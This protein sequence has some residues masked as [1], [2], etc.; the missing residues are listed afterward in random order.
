LRKAFSILIIVGILWI[1]GCS[2]EEV[3]KDGNTSDIKEMVEEYSMGDFP[4]V[5]ATITNSELIVVNEKEEEK[6]YHLPEE[7][8]FLSIA[9]YEE[10]THPCV[11]H[12]LTGCQGEMVNE[13]VQMEI[14]NRDGE[15][16]LNEEMQTMDNGFIDLW[17]PRNDVYQVKIMHEGKQAEAILSTSDDGQ[18]CITTM[19]LKSV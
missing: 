8:F 16:I 2:G 10:V 15:L 1:A 4:D 9:P 18:T 13:T 11:D 7:E 17:L 12:S 6:R 19:Q 3:A 14:K 5:S